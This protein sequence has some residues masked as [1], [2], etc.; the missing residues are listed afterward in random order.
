M[1]EDPLEFIDEVSR[2]LKF[3]G[4]TPLEKVELVAYRLKDVSLMWFSQ[5]KG[6]RPVETCPWNGR[7]LRMGSIIGS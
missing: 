5:W 6:V 7:D 2:V 1:E 4:V 3:V